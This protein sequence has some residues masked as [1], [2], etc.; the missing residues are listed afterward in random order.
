MIGVGEKWDSGDLAARAAKLAHYDN[1]W[2]LT[3][4]GEPFSTHSSWLAP[5][6]ADGAPAMLKVP[7][8]PEERAAMAALA[9]YDGEGAAKVLRIDHEA[10]LMHRLADDR[11]LAAMVEAGHD[12]EAT[13]ILCAAAM[14]LHRAPAK[15]FPETAPTLRA[16]FRALPK[17]AAR[18]GAYQADFQAAWKI[19]EELL[20]QPFQPVLIHGDIHHGNVLH[21]PAH[22]WAVIDPKGLIGP[23]GYDFANMLCN[24][25]GDLPAR[26]GRLGRQA[27]IVAEATDQDLVT[28]LSWLVVYVS[29]STA[30]YAE[31]DAETAGNAHAF[32]ELC[33]AELA[34]LG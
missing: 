32:L 28:V 21:D 27:R 19:A 7:T 16:W 18:E 34:A 2:E 26:P 6:R 22:G 1:L 3:P 15:P 25:L 8:H 5:V 9:W 29:L 20:S 24:P 31:D 33:W 30:W 11:P 13:R 17:M 10:I 23:R 12:D 4:D 14:R